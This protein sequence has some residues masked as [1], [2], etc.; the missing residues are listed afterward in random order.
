MPLFLSSWVVPGGD[1]EADSQW[2]RLRYRR[3]RCCWMTRT[4]YRLGHWLRQPHLLAE[5]SLE[6][7]P[8]SPF[9]FRDQV[10]VF[11]VQ[12][13]AVVLRVLGRFVLA[14]AAAAVAAAAALREVVLES[15]QAHPAKRQT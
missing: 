7:H 3:C 13:G 6:G 15:S 4:S 11:P 2:Y 14:A 8:L 12:E 1:D 10:L 9:A 5:V